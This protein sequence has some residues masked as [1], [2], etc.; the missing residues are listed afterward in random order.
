ML[1]LPKPHFSSVYYCELLG[2]NWVKL[3]LFGIW[4]YGFL[5]LCVKIRK[6]KGLKKRH[7]EEKGMKIVEVLSTTKNQR[8]ATHI[9]IKGLGLLR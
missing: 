7:K 2:G 8:I 1:V 3:F 4:V 5:G 9:H 6:K